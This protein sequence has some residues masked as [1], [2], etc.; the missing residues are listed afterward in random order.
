MPATGLAPQA[1]GGGLNM[2]KRLDE[3][4]NAIVEDEFLDGTHSS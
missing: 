4:A 1:Y 3:H 2:R